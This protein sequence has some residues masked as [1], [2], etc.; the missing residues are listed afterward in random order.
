MES[1]KEKMMNKTDKRVAKWW[2][3]GNKDL[4]SLARKIGRPGDIGRVKEALRREKLL[5]LGTTWE[6]VQNEIDDITNHML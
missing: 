2:R 6:D 3:E 5:G 4:E 1:W